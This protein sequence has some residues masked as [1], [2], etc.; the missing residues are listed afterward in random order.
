MNT[1]FPTRFQKKAL[2]TSITFLS[3]IVIGAL[4]VGIIWLV[5]M[6]I[7][8]LQPL[9]IPLAIAGV[10][11]YLLYPAVQKLVDRGAPQK[12]ASLI[13]FASFMVISSLLMVAVILPVAGQ[14][15]D[16]RKA[17]PSTTEEF[18]EIFQ[19]KIQTP[20]SETRK[21]YE[22]HPIFGQLVAWMPETG[23]T[24]VLA[25]GGGD[26]EPPSLPP[27]QLAEWEAA[28]KASL[29]ALAGDNRDYFAWLDLENI[30][31]EILE[32]APEQVGNI[33]RKS[34]GG[35]L[36]AFG[37]LFG[38]FLVPIYL[39]FFLREAPTIREK[40]S[41]YLPLRASKFKTEV[42]STLTEINSYL[43]AFFRGQMLVSLIDGCI[44]AILL[45]ALGLKFSLLIG[46]F[47]GILGVIPYIGIIICY[48]PALIIATVQGAQAKSGQ[49]EI[50]GMFPMTEASWW[51]LPVAVTFVFV[52]VNNL[53]GIL[54][55][56]KIVGDSVGLHPFTII[57]S[58][59]FWSSLLGGLLGAILA[60]PLTAS[61][62]VIFQRYIWKRGLPPTED[63][64]FSAP[65]AA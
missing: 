2:W 64:E 19:E 57:F 49:W 12:R 37:I 17:L 29:T 45:S 41:D 54:I 28:S 9:L 30:K 60:V 52:A 27:E 21:K 13:V 39:F 1:N 42:V 36:G 46:V 50:L 22:G 62:K 58:V 6:L 61:I 53:D 31:T 34:I 55:A 65:P 40:W 7:G 20:L 33:I 38:F 47:V 16:L 44:T 26:G 8:Y 51:Y 10:L 14:A 59:L 63:P 56:P 24:R 11:T 3:L 18:R 32:R 25:P 4:G 23:N 15:G 48:I 43:I 5:T 35:F